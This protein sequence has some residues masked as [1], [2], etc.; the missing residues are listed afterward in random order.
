MPSSPNRHANAGREAQDEPESCEN[1]RDSEGAVAAQ[2][3]GLAPV[4]T[5]VTQI[6]ASTASTPAKP[7]QPEAKTFSLKRKREE[8]DSQLPP[9]SSALTEL[10]EQ[11]TASPEKQKQILEPSSNGLSAET[12][13]SQVHDSENAAS[14]GQASDADRQHFSPTKHPKDAMAERPDFQNDSTAHGHTSS[15]E[16]EIMDRAGAKQIGAAS[17]APTP[18]KEE[19]LAPVDEDVSVS[20][21]IYEVVERLLCS[22]EQQS[23]KRKREDED[24][25]AQCLSP[26]SRALKPC[27]GEAG[28]ATTG[29]KKVNEATA[30]SSEVEQ[31]NR[32]METAASLG[33]F[34]EVS[35]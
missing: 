22:V 31:V 11:S 6:A 4:P 30:S 35:E 15:A 7:R 16:V 29:E 27:H 24:G 33:R 19:D 13:S 14:G 1:P 5:E 8:N 3:G 34:A 17:E 32:V 12:L 28:A 9:S 25:N 20:A 18:V 26:S 21:Q 23:T 2:D 10:Q